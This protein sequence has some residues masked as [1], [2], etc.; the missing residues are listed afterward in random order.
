MDFA[1]LLAQLTN[2]GEEGPGEGIYD[3]LSASYTEA[4]STRD[5]KIGD[6]DA[7]IASLQAELT[8]AKLINYELMVA[9]PVAS[10]D[11]SGN[12]GESN[13]SD[14]DIGDD[15]DFFEKEND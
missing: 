7:I 6:Q 10:T 8:A 15:D 2:P 13:E 11:D 14:D 5:A 3:D 4:T 12:D 1:T 9:A